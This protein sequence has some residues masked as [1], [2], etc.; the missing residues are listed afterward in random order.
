M[1]PWK[2]GVSTRFHARTS[3]RGTHEVVDDSEVLVVVASRADAALVLVE[4]EP[5]ALG[6]VGVR[7]AVRVREGFRVRPLDRLS[8]RGRIGIALDL[9]RLPPPDL[10]RV[11]LATHRR[12]RGS[13]ISTGK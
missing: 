3:R 4:Q 13:G 9:G 1:I 7:E 2:R 10:D 12:Q 8:E 5:S 11:G 6:R